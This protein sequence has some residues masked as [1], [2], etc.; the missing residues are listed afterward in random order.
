MGQMDRDRP[1]DSN[2]PR[3]DESSVAEETSATGQ[4]VKGAIKDATGEVTGNQSLE[5]K[6]ERENQAGKDRQ[7]KND[8]V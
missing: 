2:A 3:H 6:G 5:D 7:K 4:R 8:A 1:D